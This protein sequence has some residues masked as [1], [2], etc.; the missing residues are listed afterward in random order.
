MIRIQLNCEPVPRITHHDSKV[1][2]ESQRGD[3]PTCPGGAMW[4]A[5]SPR[6]RLRPGCRRGY[7]QMGLPQKRAWSSL[8]SSPLDVPKLAGARSLAANVTASNQSCARGGISRN[9][10]LA[11]VPRPITSTALN[12]LIM[13]PP[14]RFMRVLNVSFGSKAGVL[15]TP[16]SHPPSAIPIAGERTVLLTFI[17]PRQHVGQR[18]AHGAPSGWRSLLR[19][20]AP[21]ALLL[22][23]PH[24]P[25]PQERSEL[26]LAERLAHLLR[27]RAHPGNGLFQLFRRHAQ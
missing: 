11:P 15:R 20:P 26:L 25:E 13:E 23:P 6:G 1:S 24:C 27:R 3:I 7:T 10:A 2:G 22:G 9:D 18:E 4:R 5:R 14:C 21:R 12:G 16:D 17:D 8:R 19:V